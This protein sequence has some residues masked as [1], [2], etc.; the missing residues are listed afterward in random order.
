MAMIFD[1]GLPRDEMLAISGFLASE[2]EADVPE[3]GDEGAKVLDAMTTPRNPNSLWRTVIGR[4]VEFT[5][6]GP[7]GYYRNHEGEL[8]RVADAL[9]GDDG[10]ATGRYGTVLADYEQPDAAYVIGVP[11]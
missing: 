11:L 7:S 5:P 6:V 8:V 1:I 3:V 2:G 10:K 4:F 9:M